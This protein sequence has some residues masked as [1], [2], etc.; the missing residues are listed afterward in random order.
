MFG[1]GTGDLNVMQLS[2]DGS[3]GATVWSETGD[4][5]DQWKEGTVTISFDSPFRVS[6]FV[7][8]EP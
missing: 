4:K 6:F 2:A 8:K 7:F 5:G 3:S 1:M